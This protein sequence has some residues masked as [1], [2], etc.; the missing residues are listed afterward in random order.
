MNLSKKI[1]LLAPAKSAEIGIAAINCG[2]DAVYIGAE[3]FSARENAGNALPDIEK[4]IAHAHRYYARV[5][6]ALNTILKN[7]E[8][9]DALKLVKNLYAI[10]ADGLIVQDVGL[11]E[12]PLPP[13]PLI[14]S[15]QMNND[16]LA[17]IVFLEKIGFRRVI[18][19][20]EMTLGEIKE[21]GAAT[22]IELESFVHGSLCVSCSGQC[23]LSYA[24]GGRSA[25]RGACAQPCRRLYSLYDENG[26]LLVKDKHLLSLKDL[27]RS[28]RLKE[29][30]DAGITSFKI[31]GRLKDLAYVTN[32]VSF[33]RQKLDSLLNGGARTKGSSGRTSFD[34][35]PD[36]FK[37][38]NRG[39]TEYLLDGNNEHM[40]SPHTPKSLGEKI[41][42]VARAGAGYFT[43]S[44]RHDLRN[45]DGICFFDASGVLQG[46]LLHKIDGEK[47]Y[48]DK[49]Y[50]IKEKT[51]LYRN[52]DRLFAK[53]LEKIPC[54]RRIDVS[55]AL[56][57]AEDGFTINARDEDGNSGTFS[58]AAE[59]IRAEKKS[60]A[61]S[62]I[63]NQ[64]AKLN[65][66][67]F[68]CA[69]ISIQ[70]REIYLI[71]FSI[72]NQ[73]RRGV[74]LALLAEREKNR[75]QRTQQIMIS[76]LPYPLKSIDYLGNCL[77]KKAAA[78][79]ERHGASV[80]EPAAESGIEMA[81]RRVMNLKYCVKKDL[82]LCKKNHGILY[83]VDE[84][85]R[86]F[87]LKCDCAK[88]GMELFFPPRTNP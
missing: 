37:T 72:A 17:K 5:Y 14:A 48:P 46:S 31:E 21:I 8:L 26:K 16:S 57:E 9:D 77:N 85:N 20:R 56:E 29:L 41:G 3:Q 12:M 67:I 80:V 54:K 11:L 36:P 79:Y 47:I 74:I 69:D 63:R 45:G 13:I 61:E 44:G 65:D 60:L 70:L 35:M 78:F 84:D 4:L 32:I 43:L 38:F 18:L 62:S 59:K 27:N 51:V 25:N 82:G 55:F 83:L 64:L 30:M 23:Y 1:E 24:I 42:T 76:E 33:Y 53:T 39:Y 52:L 81:G 7:D 49:M 66:T 86:K 88:C 2:A 6:V 68:T 15:T 28:A 34:F 50:G 87:L 40:A 19:P 75:P 71:P 22:A 58:I 73:L 10:G